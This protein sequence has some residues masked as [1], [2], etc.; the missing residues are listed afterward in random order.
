[1]H[2]LEIIIYV[3][4]VLYVLVKIYVAE[5]YSNDSANF[6]WYYCSSHAWLKCIIM[7]VLISVG[8]TAVDMRGRHL[9]IMHSP[10]A[11]PPRISTEIP[12]AVCSHCVVQQ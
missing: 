8:T 3:D 9:E 4:M 1:V 12:E 6:S 5:M 10:S 7:T 11:V 2:S